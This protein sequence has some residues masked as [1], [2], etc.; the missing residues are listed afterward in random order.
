MMGDMPKR[1]VL[2]C[3]DGSED[4]KHAI[5]EAGSFMV[6]RDAL[7]LTVWQDAE[8]IPSLAWA[9]AT[10]PDLEDVFAAARD[11]AAR[12]AEEGAGIARAVG[13]AAG[14]LV[15]E[16]KGPIWVAVQRVIDEHDVSVVVVGSRGLSGVKSLLLGS[17]STGIVHHVTR[18]VVVVRR[19]DA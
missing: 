5:R 17:V 18:P 19:A 16:A 8:A 10:L 15:D 3:F 9:A 2:F 11:G 13:F 7:V 14:A 4:A 1:P 6:L 12:V